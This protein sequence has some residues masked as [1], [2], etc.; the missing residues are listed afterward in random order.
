MGLFRWGSRAE[1]FSVFAAAS[2]PQLRRAA[3]L[4]CGDWHRAEDLTQQAL[5]KIYVHWASV[6]RTEIPDAYARKILLRCWLDECRRKSSSDVVGLEAYDAVAPAEN[7][8]LRLTMEQALGALP[9]KQRAVVVLRYWEDL[10]IATV[11]D[12]LDCS[13]GT[14]K[15]NAKRGLDA[16][17]TV[18]ENQGI[19]VS[20]G[21]GGVLDGA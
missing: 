20:M 18:L 11:A 19:L 5:T 4:L 2:G 14:V 10:D 7:H 9:P 12:M 21:W 6:R 1:E 15:S 8:D 3:Y 17:R 13:P 16:L